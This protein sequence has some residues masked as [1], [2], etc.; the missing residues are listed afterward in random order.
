M[1]SINSRILTYLKDKSLT[2]KEFASQIGVHEKTLGNKLTGRIRIDLET[3]EAILGKFP[4]LSAEWLL[5]GTGQMEI[6]DAR[7][8]T[9]LEAVCIDQAK[10]ILRLKLRIA[11]LEGEKK[12]A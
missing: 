3:I 10:E 6:D 5:R 1:E 2:I 9:E 11:E 4:M 12:L 8:S 7:Q